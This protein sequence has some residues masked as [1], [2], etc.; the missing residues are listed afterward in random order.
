M[1]YPVHVPLLSSLLLYLL[2][3]CDKTCVH[4]SIPEGKCEC[5]CDEQWHGNKCGMYV[6]IITTISPPPP[7]K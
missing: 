6:I 4:G 3:I 1:I 2:E 5:A 7:P